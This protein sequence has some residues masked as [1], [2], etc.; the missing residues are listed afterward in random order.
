MRLNF[1]PNKTA[2]PGST[3]AVLRRAYHEAGGPKG[4]AERIGARRAQ[5]YN[6]AD[7]DHPSAIRHDQV[8]ALVRAGAREPVHDL[9]ALAGGHFVPAEASAGTAAALAGQ[10]A[11]EHGAFAETL[12][13][14]LDDGRIEKSEAAALAAQLDDVIRVLVCARTK[15]MA[16]NHE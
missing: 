13:V 15:L 9:C 3:E 12:I 1:Q 5:V 14:A 7:P 16:V 2:K 8:R 10:G 6:Y 11:R 4:V